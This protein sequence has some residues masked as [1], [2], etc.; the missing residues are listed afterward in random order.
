MS[1]KMTEGLRWTEHHQQELEELEATIEPSKLQKWLHDLEIWEDDESGMK[2]NPF[3]S[4][5]MRMCSRLFT[6]WSL[7]QVV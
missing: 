5:T 6:M 2:M 4:Q 7:N 1:R 3:E